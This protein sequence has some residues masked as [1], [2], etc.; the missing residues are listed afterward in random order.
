MEQN[1]LLNV[2]LN[3]NR[4][5]TGIENLTKFSGYNQQVYNDSS[6]SG[7]GLI[8]ITKPSLFIQP[9]KPIYNNY[10]ESLAYNNMCKDPSFTYYI[11]GENTNEK[12]LLV[13]KELSYFSYSDIQSLFLPIFTNCALNISI[14]DTNLD[15]TNSFQSKEGYSIPMPTTKIPSEAASTITITVNETSNLDFYKTIQLWVDY[16][17]NISKGIFSA[18][19]DMIKNNMIDYTSSIYYFMLAPDGR[20]L[21]YWC[22]FTSAFPTSKIANAFSYQKGSHDNIT[23]DI[24]F[25]YTLKEEM[26]PQILEDFN[27]LSLKLVNAIFADESYSSFLNSIENSTSLGYNSYSSSQLLSKDNLFSGQFSKQ[28]NDASR[29]PLIFYEKSVESSTTN[30]KTVGKYVISFGDDSLN[31]TLYNSIL[32]NESFTY[33]FLSK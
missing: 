15:T 33:S 14:P 28:A 13:V 30:D 2:Y 12:D 10:N 19:P 21:K 17:Y 25:Q 16:I 9:I 29:D 23:I 4:D 6:I 7:Y 3:K 24:P 18:N 20:T 5:Q 1:N 27:M 11:N 22:R 26:N 8:F 32:G 31:N